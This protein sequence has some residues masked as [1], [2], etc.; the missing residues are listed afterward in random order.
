MTKRTKMTKIKAIR[1]TE[2]QL[3]TLNILRKKYKINT[4][5]F[6]RLAIDEKLQRDKD[7][8]FKNYKEI[9]DYIKKYS[10][11]PF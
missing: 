3:K 8:I 1:F 11:I 5:E 7:F 4:S 2:N 10:D 9:Q 6:I